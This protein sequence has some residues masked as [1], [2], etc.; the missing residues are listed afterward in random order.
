MPSV[1]GVWAEE[2]QPRVH[3]KPKPEPLDI[4]Q[5][6]HMQFFTCL[7]CS[8]TASDSQTGEWQVTQVHLSVLYL[9]T[10]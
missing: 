6:E 2:D 8:S 10:F 5:F 9:N 4:S 3:P 7:N 1:L